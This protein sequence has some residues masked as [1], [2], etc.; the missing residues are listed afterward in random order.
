MQRIILPVADRSDEETRKVNR[1]NRSI[2][3][4]IVLLTLAFSTVVMS[5]DQP[6]VVAARKLLDVMDTKARLSET[7]DKVL[8]VQVTANPVLIPYKGVMRQFLERYLGFENLRDEL[9]SLYAESFSTEELTEIIRFYESPVGK[10]TI[11]QFPDLFSKGMAIGQ[12]RV[13]DHTAELKELI[14]KEAERLKNLQQDS[15]VKPVK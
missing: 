15:T 8:E 11:T 10:K 14:E 4:G 7:I 2:A 12:K 6:N 1:M 9:V 5:E 13:A 3:K